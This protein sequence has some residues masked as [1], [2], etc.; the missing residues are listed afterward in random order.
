MLC[1]QVDILHPLTTL[2]WEQCGQIPKKLR[3]DSIKFVALGEKIYMSSDTDLYVSTDLNSWT[4]LCKL[5]AYQGTL[6][7]YRSQLVLVGGEEDNKTTNNKLWTL[8]EAG[9]WQESLPPMPTECYEPV[10][11]SATDPECLIVMRRDYHHFMK[12]RNGLLY[13]TK[14]EVLIGD[15]W[16][17]T[18]HPPSESL[19]GGVVHNGILYSGTGAHVVCCDFESLIASCRHPDPNNPLKW[20]KIRLMCGPMISILSFRQQ[21]VMVSENEMFA[22]QPLTDRMPWVSLGNIVP[23]SEGVILSAFLHAGSLLVLVADQQGYSEFTIMRLSLISKC[24]A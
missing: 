7:T 2:K 9:V 21:L 11:V 24:S 1:L 19:V 14:M 15:R 13:K 12:E 6:T 5:P 18:E 8:S 17:I 4:E 20:S 23:I 16:F 3:G 22:Y 10:V